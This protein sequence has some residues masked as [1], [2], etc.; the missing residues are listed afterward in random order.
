MIFKLCLDKCPIGCTGNSNSLSILATLSLCIYIYL[1]TICIDILTMRCAIANKEVEN[2]VF[3][4][5]YGTGDKNVLSSATACL[6]TSGWHF[7]NCPCSISW[8]KRSFDSFGGT[9]NSF[10]SCRGITEQRTTKVCS[11]PPRCSASLC[12]LCIWL[13]LGFALHFHGDSI[14]K[15]L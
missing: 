10:L 13:N 1:Y 8:M 14:E 15:I 11:S 9:A 6:A 12:I 7:T 4:R 3:E 5:T 2:G